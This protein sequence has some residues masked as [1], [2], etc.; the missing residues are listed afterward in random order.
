M[1]K[2]VVIAHFEFI[3][4]WLNEHDMLS[5]DGLEILEI[6]IDEDV[7]LHEGLV[8]ESGLIFLNKF[9]DKLITD[10]EYDV[11]REKVLI[12]ILFRE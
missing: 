3:F 2:E 7:S 4:Q 8:N 9:Y 10:S 1:S 6:G 12:D 5:P 11:A